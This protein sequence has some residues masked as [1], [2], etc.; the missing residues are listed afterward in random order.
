[1]TRLSDI[2]NTPIADI[3]SRE[4]VRVSPVTPL[5]DVVEALRERGRGA[6]FVEDGGKLT[7]IFTERDVLERI[8]HSNQSWHTVA[9]REVM[10]PEPT[11]INGDQTLRD[12]IDSMIAGHFRH[13][14]IVGASG[15]L[16]GVLSI[17]D[18]LTHIAEYFP[19]DF[20]NLPPDPD[21]EASEP[22]G[23]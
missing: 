4:P 16:L 19:A 8:D 1:M 9:I 22:W 23:G 14:P 17:R 21:H 12:A 13:L 18:L 11:T 20:L 5:L 10:T 2:A 15:E 3:A 7:G 6:A